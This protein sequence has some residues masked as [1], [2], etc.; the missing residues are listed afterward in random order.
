MKKTWKTTLFAV[1]L[2][3]ALLFQ[4]LGT[5]YAE[6]TSQLPETAALH[7]AET[8]A[9]AAGTGGSTVSFARDIPIRRTRSGK[10]KTGS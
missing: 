1:I 3:T 4:T 7:L 8:D 10:L 5:A 6:G 9:G 2:A